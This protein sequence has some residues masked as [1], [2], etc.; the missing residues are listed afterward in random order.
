MIVRRGEEVEAQDVG[1]V[2]G[3]GKLGIRIQWFINNDVGDDSYVHNFAMRQFTF[4]PGV[5]YPLHHHKYVEG[6]YVVSGHGYFEND[7]ERIE[8]RPGDVIYTASQEPHGIGNLGNE[9]LVMVCAIDCV[10]GGGNCSTRS[11]AVKLTK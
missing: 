8:V 10:D 1:E 2:L 7:K 4:D 6:V 11:R 5:S 3:T 9:P